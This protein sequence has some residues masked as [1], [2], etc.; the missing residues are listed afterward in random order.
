[1][2]VIVS[3]NCVRLQSQ[4]MG[5]V[6]SRDIR[7]RE[8]DKVEREEVKSSSVCVPDFSSYDFLPAFDVWSNLQFKEL[9]KANG[10]WRNGNAE[11]G[12]SKCKFEKL[13][14]D[15][16]LLGKKFD[17]LLVLQQ[18]EIFARGESIHAQGILPPAKSADSVSALDFF[19]GLCLICK[20]TLEQ[21]SG[22][23]FGLFDFGRRKIL[24]TDETLALMTCSMRGY[25]TMKNIPMPDG[26]GFR[27]L[28]DSMMDNIQA[29]RG[30]KGNMIN[31]QEF[32]AW[33]KRDSSANVVLL[34]ASLVATGDD[35]AFAEFKRQEIKK[36]LDELSKIELS[37]ELLG[38]NPFDNH[39]IMDIIHLKQT[40]QET[41]PVKSR[42]NAGFQQLFIY[43]LYPLL[44]QFAMT[45]VP[46]KSFA[47]LTMEQYTTFNADERHEWSSA[48]EYM[49]EL[50]NNIHL[51]FNTT[52]LVGFTP[53]LLAE[54][55]TRCGVSVFSEFSKADMAGEIGF[56]TFLQWAQTWPMAEFVKLNPTTGNYWAWARVLVTVG[57]GVKSMLFNRL[58]AVL[59]GNAVPL[60]NSM[61]VDCEGSMVAR[62][63]YQISVGRFKRDLWIF[64]G[65]FQFYATGP[66]VQKHIEFN[67]VIS[68]T[69]DQVDDE[70]YQV[71]GSEFLQ[72][73]QQLYEKMFLNLGSN[74]N[75]GL[76]DNEECMLLDFSCS[77]A[78]SAA[79]VT[80]SVLKLQYFFTH[81]YWRDFLTGVHVV[82]FC[83][84]VGGARKLR[85]ALFYPSNDLL[86]QLAKWLNGIVECAVTVRVGSACV[87]TACNAFDLEELWD[88]EG[89]LSNKGEK[90]IQEIFDEFDQDNDGIL[91][92]GEVNRLHVFTGC[93]IYESE[94]EYHETLRE[95]GIDCSK[96]GDITLESLLQI[97]R[98]APKESLAQDMGKT[99][100]HFAS[101]ASCP[102][103]FIL[104]YESR[105]SPESCETCT[106]IDHFLNLVASQDFQND[107]HQLLKN[108]GTCMS[109]AIEFSHFCDFIKYIE[110]YLKPL[111]EPQLY[112]HLYDMLFKAGYFQKLCANSTRI[113]RIYI[114]ALNR[115]YAGCSEDEENTE[116][117]NPTEE[118][119][120]D[121][122]STGERTASKDYLERIFLKMT[123]N[124]VDTCQG[125]IVG[126]SG[127]QIRLGNDSTFEGRFEGV[128]FFDWIT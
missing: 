98:K 85:V 38:E 80:M 99:G 82:Q 55:A 45:S 20:G 75:K 78:V 87:E 125:V 12:L 71:E 35:S 57:A 54:L 100:I 97:Y 96:S 93:D 66:P 127:F 72:K 92:L 44:K 114:E 124:L 69:T 56:G 41:K 86:G 81:E 42:R 103:E 32:V 22:F 6:Y 89:V 14:S 33:C 3:C 121:T 84:F 31:L 108:H 26:E 104:K 34:N 122:D 94:T 40:L 36:V 16:K 115:G 27:Y 21:R 58:R 107:I 68:D 19:G 61:W 29:L 73:G 48:T 83:E 76:N 116:D 47:G 105:R 120:E 119:R 25:C 15:S 118:E 13:L 64:E 74:W 60:I 4:R 88:D 18:F 62:N 117:I 28:N 39:E 11:L 43:K 95:D 9:Q 77:A 10:I 46:D 63:L 37:L 110:R 5:K 51:V 17:R 8:I 23:L 123:R 52:E 2:N 112:S 70:I 1:M 113:A 111:L 24:T 90:M 67:E 109:S 49:D 50:S 126:I 53:Q 102:M 7:A 30:N 65:T 128:D 79:Q 101:L 59:I 106:P 91:N